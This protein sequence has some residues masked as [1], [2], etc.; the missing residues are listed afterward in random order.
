MKM[1]MES[2]WDSVKINSV[3]CQAKEER[4]VGLLLHSLSSSCPGEYAG[5]AKVGLQL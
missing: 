3:N 1:D 4:V 2:V 5:G